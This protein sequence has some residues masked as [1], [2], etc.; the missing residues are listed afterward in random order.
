MLASRKSALD[1][2]MPLE[3]PLPHVSMVAQHNSAT[4]HSAGDYRG[5][6]MACC[7][8]QMHKSHACLSLASLQPKD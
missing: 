4:G 7:A 3:S 8:L 6:K 2:I 1:E 5:L